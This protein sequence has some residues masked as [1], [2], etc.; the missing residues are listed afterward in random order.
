MVRSAS[1]RVSNHEAP[2]SPVAILRDAAK[3]PLLRMRSLYATTG[4][5]REIASTISAAT[6]QS[7]PAT[8]NAGR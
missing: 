5:G 7:A 2:I 6:T 8:K 1:S 3:W 4:F